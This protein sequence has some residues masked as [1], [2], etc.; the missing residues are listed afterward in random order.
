MAGRVMTPKKRGGTV[1][2]NT[3]NRKGAKLRAKKKKPERGCN[4]FTAA[5]EYIAS[6]MAPDKSPRERASLIRAIIRELD[7]GIFNRDWWDVC[8]LISTVSI[9]STP[10]SVPDPNPPPYNYR[11]GTNLPTIPTY[12]AGVLGN[13][14]MRYNGSKSG[15]YFYDDSLSWSRFIFRIKA[16]RGVSGALHA[17]YVL[18]GSMD[19][20]ASHRASKPM[21]S[22]ISTAAIASNG[23]AILTTLDPVTRGVPISAP[24]KEAATQSHYWRYKIPASSPPYFSHQRLYPIVRNAI[25]MATISASGAWDRAMLLL[26]PRPMFGRGF[27]NNEAIQTTL[28]CTPVLYQIY[29]DANAGGVVDL[30]YGLS[31][32]TFSLR[33]VSAGGE[34]INDIYTH[35]GSAFGKYFYETCDVRLLGQTSRICDIAFRTWFSDL[36]YEIN[37][38]WPIGAITY[39]KAT[40]TAEWHIREAHFFGIPWIH[41]LEIIN[42]KCTQRQGGIVKKTEESRETV[43]YFDLPY[44]FAYYARS[45]I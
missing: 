27:N 45:T 29:I 41:N 6:Q 9:N 20:S 39:D 34:F 19:I 3:T 43:G 33:S 4:D 37:G 44:G 17:F 10:T 42:Y 25:K 12:P 31:P 35:S 26:A 22:A 28:T 23:D 40:K 14:F 21:L 16:P 36:Y 18:N 13:Y 7:S 32:R 5:A 2:T 15:N 30:D 24:T 11:T 1:V 38:Y 8:E